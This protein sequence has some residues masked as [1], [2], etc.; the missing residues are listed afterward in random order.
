VM[1]AVTQGGVYVDFDDV[2]D[3]TAPHVE[4]ATWADVILVVPATANFLGKVANGIA[5][6]LLTTTLLAASCPVVIVPVTNTAM[7]SKPAV[8]RNVAQLREDG[9]EVVEP[10]EGVSL[11]DGRA[12]AG[13]LGDYRPAVVAAIAKAMSSRDQRPG[14]SGGDGNR[15]PRPGEVNAH[16]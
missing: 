16:G 3:A 4:L 6:D 14:T 2:P 13:S 10:K 11:A 8:Q 1:Q 9:Y 12:E 7:W 15:S 5:D